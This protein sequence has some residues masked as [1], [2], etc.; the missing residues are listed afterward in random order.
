ML[1]IGVQAEAEQLLEDLGFNQLPV[2]LDDIFGSIS[3]EYPIEIQEKNMHS[4]DINGMSVGDTTQ[5]KIL[6]NSNINNIHRRRFTKAH[7]LGHVILHIQTGKQ[8]E[9]RCTRKDI[10]SIGGNNNQLEKE[11]NIFASSLLMPSSLILNDIYRNDLSWKLIQDIRNMCD[12][13]L[14]AAARRVIYLSKE[15]CCLIIHKNKEMWM[16]VS[17]PSFRT[18][19]QKQ[20]FPSNLDY[21]NDNESQIFSDNMEECDFSDWHFSSDA[22][23]VL[24]YT[25]IYNEQYDRRMTLLLHNE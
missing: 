14:E 19:I 12:V 15:P 8:S 11:A 22:Q 2:S 5:A 4:G 21:E 25:S 17:S 23:G 1:D 20:P 16:P 13:S 18:F 9:F 6:I 10:S 24:S 7:E 3:R